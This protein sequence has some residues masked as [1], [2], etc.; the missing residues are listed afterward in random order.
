MAHQPNAADKAYDAQITAFDKLRKAVDA[1]PPGP[2]QVE[3]RRQGNAMVNVPI[4]GEAT[5][6]AAQRR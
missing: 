2:T 5:Q 6:G 4:D 3:A 1:P